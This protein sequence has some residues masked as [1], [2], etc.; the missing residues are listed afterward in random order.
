[1]RIHEAHRAAADA[2]AARPDRP[3]TA[4]VHD[5][6]DVRLM[7]FRIE[8]G[9]QVATHTNASTVVLTVL[10]GTGIVTGADGERTVGPGS[11]VTYEPREPHGMRANSERFILIAAIAPRPGERHDGPAKATPAAAVSRPP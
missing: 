8:P 11:V 4:V 9:Q 3:A 7:V 6:A 1:M 2:V 5:S 10:E